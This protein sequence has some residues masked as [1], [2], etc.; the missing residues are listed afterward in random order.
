MGDVRMEITKLT[1]SFAGILKAPGGDRD[2]ELEA[3]TARDRKRMMEILSSK[4]RV[5][6]LLY[7]KAFPQKAALLDKW[8][9]EGPTSDKALKPLE[10]DM[11][12]LWSRW[13]EWTESQGSAPADGPMLPPLVEASSPAASMR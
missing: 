2:M 8:T 13:K 11:N 12:A 5:L 10:V 9:T 3:Y 7:E 1:T 6:Q 4:E